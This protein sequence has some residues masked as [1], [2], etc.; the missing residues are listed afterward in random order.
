MDLTLLHGSYTFYQRA[1]SEIN[2]EYYVSELK[3][4]VARQN[5]QKTKEFQNYTLV[6]LLRH[7][8]NNTKSVYVEYRLLKLCK[9]SLS[10][11]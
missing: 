2:Q 4:E 1:K 5:S 7:W 6:I 9:M 11:N 8:P 10:V 3:P